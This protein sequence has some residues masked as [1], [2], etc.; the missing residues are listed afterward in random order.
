M[1]RAHRCLKRNG[2][3]WK[4]HRQHDTIP[5][6]T[7]HNGWNKRLKWQADIDD[8]K[9]K[10]KTGCYDVFW[11]LS[12]HIH[13]FQSQSIYRKK[14]SER[15]EWGP[16]MGRIFMK[17]FSFK[18]RRNWRPDSCL[19]IQGPVKWLALLFNFWEKAETESNGNKER[20]KGWNVR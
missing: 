3:K 17:H 15:T 12:R 7:K 18:R 6:M 2:N 19:L 8:L 11:W 20:G 5:S 16:M 4:R 10:I 14:E 13:Y 1:T 9:E